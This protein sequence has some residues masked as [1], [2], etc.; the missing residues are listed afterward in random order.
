MVLSTSELPGVGWKQRTQHSW[1][2]GSSRIINEEA[3]RAYEQGLFAALRSFRLSNVRELDLEVVPYSSVDDARSMIPKLWRNRTPYPNSL[4]VA[5]EQIID[6]R[7]VPEISDPWLLEQRSAGIATVV[8]VII[9]RV[10]HVVLSVG[11]IALR[12]DWPW[13]EVEVL[14]SL[15]GKKV[16]QVLGADRC[17]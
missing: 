15:Q 2:I 11:C 8:R 5:E 17:A 12:D 16:L 6:G 4:T 9:G 13:D 14:A 3:R 7:K 1:R 10:D